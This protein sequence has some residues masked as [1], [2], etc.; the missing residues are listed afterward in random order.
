MN[1]EEDLINIADQDMLFLEEQLK[2]RQNIIDH[3]DKVIAM[4]KELQGMIDS[5]PKD[6]IKMQK[7][8]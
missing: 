3:L 6:P 4:V 8:H 7:S 1:Q 2:T 5:A